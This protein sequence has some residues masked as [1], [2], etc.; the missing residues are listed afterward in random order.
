MPNPGG[1]NQYTRF[2]KEPPL[3]HSKRLNELMRAVTMAGA[4]GTTS[5]INA[6]KNSQRKAVRGDAKQVQPVRPAGRDRPVQPQAQ[7]PPADAP[8]GLL[9]PEAQ[10]SAWWQQVAMIPG[11]SDLAIEYANESVGIRAA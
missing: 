11:V 9:P 1:D 8:D 5:A 6:P 3:G 10:V 7:P 2:Q 4:Q